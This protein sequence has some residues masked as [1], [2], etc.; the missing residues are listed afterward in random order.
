MVDFMWTNL[1]EVF[2]FKLKNIRF[3]DQH[4]YMPIAQSTSAD[5][6]ELTV[7]VNSAYRGDSS[8]KGWTTESHL[9]DGNRIDEDAIAGY[10]ATPGIF[11]LK[12]TDD[13][14]S[15]SGCVYLEDKG[16]ALYLGMLSVSPL[17]QAT[18]IGRILLLEAELLASQLGLPVIN[19]TVISTRTELIEWYQRRGYKATG[20]VRPFHCDERFG[21]P[22]ETIELIVMEKTL[23]P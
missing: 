11:I 18:G 21:I 1:A 9:L 22:R 23:S 16:D 14:G 7:L 5:I 17:I 13:K 10:L 12:H 19:I 2:H 3:D 15:I 20:E 4:N 8:K 6:A